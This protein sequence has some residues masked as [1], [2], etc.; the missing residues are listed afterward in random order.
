MAWLFPWQSKHNLLP[1]VSESIIEA[2]QNSH[3]VLDLSVSTGFVLFSF[4]VVGLILSSDGRITP[5]ESDSK[6]LSYSMSNFISQ[7]SMQLLAESLKKKKECLFKMP[8][9]VFYF[10]VFS[11][12]EQKQ[13]KKVI[14]TMQT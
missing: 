8:T 14:K 4:S 2:K 1:R 10:T 13:C 12:I 6:R 9:C 11:V 7:L 3:G 5:V